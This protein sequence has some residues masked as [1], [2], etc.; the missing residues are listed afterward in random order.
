MKVPKIELGK[1][2]ENRKYKNSH[3]H[4]TVESKNPS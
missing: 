4:Q 2:V 3:L 1:T